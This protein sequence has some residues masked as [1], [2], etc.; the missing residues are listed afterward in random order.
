MMATFKDRK[1][2]EWL[3]QLDAPTVE[4]IRDEHGVNLVDLSSD[5]LLPLRNDPLLLVTVVAV[6]CREQ[7]EER[8]LSRPEFGKA[9]PS[10]PDVMLNALREAVIGFFPSGRASHLREVFAKF[11]RM[12]ETTEAISLQKMEAA[13]TDNRVLKMLNDK[14]DELISEGLAKLQIQSAGT[15]ATTAET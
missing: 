8:K 14:A 7:R 5:P 4:E 10:P 6:I 13:L 1:G 12:A 15:P 9:L 3:L 11:D 2:R